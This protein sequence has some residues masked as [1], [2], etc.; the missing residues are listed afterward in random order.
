M[1]VLQQFTRSRFASVAILDDLT[2]D[3][4]E[5]HEN[6]LRPDHLFVPRYAV[7]LAR[8]LRVRSNLYVDPCVYR[9]S[10]GD[11]FVDCFMVPRL[12]EKKEKRKEQVCTF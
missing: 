4:E 12:N 10:N 5:I 6:L 1:N 9:G 7:C 8:H 2:I 11:R 3:Q